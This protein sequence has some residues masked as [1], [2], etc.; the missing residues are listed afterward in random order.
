LPGQA[1]TAIPGDDLAG[2]YFEQ[3]CERF[4]LAAERAG[5][6]LA[7]DFEMGG[8]AVRLRC[9]GSAI[10][11]APIPP[12]EHLATVGSAVPELTISL[13]DASLSA[14][15]TSSPVPSSPRRM[16]PPC[17]FRPSHS[18]HNR[19][20]RAEFARLLKRSLD[21]RREAAP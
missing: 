15:C 13:F 19:G 2:E 8:L 14:T 11:E 5:G 6:A 21:R 10:R 4:E 7:Q 17:A 18:I 12:S 1:P 3:L 9:V 20:E 16:P